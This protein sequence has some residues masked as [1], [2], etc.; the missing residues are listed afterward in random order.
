MSKDGHAVGPLDDRTTNDLFG[1]GLLDALTDENLTE[2]ADPDDAD[3]DGIS[4]RVHWVTDH[5]GEMHVGKFGR[6]SEVAHLDEFNAEAFQNEQGVTNP[7]FGSDGRLVTGYQNPGEP[8]P[9]IRGRDLVWVALDD[10]I[11]DEEVDEHDMEFL[12]AYVRFLA[13]PADNTDSLSKKDQGRANGL[14]HST[15][16]AA[17]H[18]PE[19]KTGH[20]E[21][22]ALS[23]IK[24]SPYSDM[25]L[26]DMGSDLAEG[27]KGDATP[28]EWRTEPLWGLRFVV[29][30]YMHD[31]RAATLDAAILAHAGEGSEANNAVDAYEDLEEKDRLLL[32]DFLNTL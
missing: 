4:G 11:P 17:C 27:C 14:F 3:G 9:M 5:H 28:S 24:I 7:E 16:C 13:P 1:L 19:L 12:N 10:G 31:G 22:N 25:L 26:H 20:H 2:L 30:G 6:K 32:I 15:G 23:K 8:D 21:S 18:K 29:A